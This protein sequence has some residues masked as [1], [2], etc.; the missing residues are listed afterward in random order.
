MIPGAV[1]LVGA[2][3]R[4]WFAYGDHGFFG[5]VYFGGGGFGGG[6]GGFGGGGGGFGGGGLFPRVVLRRR[7]GGR[8]PSLT[9]FLLGLIVHSFLLTLLEYTPDLPDKT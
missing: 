9:T 5:S 2:A 4:R 1:S 3:G 6:G 7:G 8:F